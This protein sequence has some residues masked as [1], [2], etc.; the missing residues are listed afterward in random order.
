M[1]VAD[2]SIVF[3]F[4]GVSLVGTTTGMEK[5]DRSTGVRPI[6]LFMCSVVLREGYVDGFRWLSQYLKDA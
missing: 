6:E 4:I 5:I 1:G 3:L 2:V